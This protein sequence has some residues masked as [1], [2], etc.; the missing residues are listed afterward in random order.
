MSQKIKGLYIGIVG[1]IFL[2]L[3]GWLWNIYFE[4]KQNK[5]NGPAI[6]S[7]IFKEV[8][9]EDAKKAL[10]SGE[11]DMYS[12]FL[13]VADAKELKNNSAIILYPTTSTIIG[14]YVNPY[15]AKNGELNPFSIKEV[16]SAMQ[17][18]VNRQKIVDDVYSGFAQSTLTFPWKGLADYENIKNTVEGLGISYDKEKAISLIKKGMESS[19]A[20]LESGVWMY[21]NKPVIIKI[22]QSSKTLEIANILKSELDEI[23]FTTTSIYTDSND[24]EARNPESYTNAAD[25][26][27]N[28]AISGFT[29][30]GQSKINNTTI[31][32]PY[33]GDGWWEYTNKEIDVLEEKQK[34]FRTEE[35]RLTINNELVK[36][37][38]DDSTCVWLVTLDSVSAA[39]SEVKGLIQDKYIG[40]TNFTNLREAY[41][42]NKEVLIVGLPK[43]YEEK[44]GWNHW[45]IN[46]I[47]MM[48]IVNTVH[49]PA[50]WTE[51]YTLKE[52]G[53]RWFPS[54]SNNGLDAT[55]D[56]PSDS[57][58]WNAKEKKWTGVGKEKKAVTKVTYDLSRYLEANWHNGEKIT[59]ADVVYH[60]ART[61]DVASDEKKQ[62]LE[63]DQYLDVF[64][65]VIGIRI[66]NKM[67]EVYL[68]TWSVDEGELLSIAGIFQKVAP[69]ELS[70][71]TDDLVFNQ[72]LYDYHF[73]DESKNEKLNLSNAIHIAA[74]F[75]TIKGLDFAKI[76]P[77]LTMGDKVYAQKSDLDLR[78]SLLES[79]YA[80]HNHLYVSDG[81]F[82]IDSFDIPNKS[83]KLKAFRDQS[84]P[85]SA[86]HWRN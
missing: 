20:S 21:K 58:V 73:I 41:I 54:I 6:D 53:F 67:L 57:F 9:K 22:S 25:L 24:P 28:I 84:Y 55:I 71:A 10:L 42:P 59:Q 79:W 86:N 23:G 18:L 49:D 14:L 7:I 37:Y 65:P 75:K 68:N 27:W 64:K 31:L 2:I 29:F 74:I 38:L 45:T 66:D 11:I 76:Q 77:M 36:N 62:K 83:I 19:G 80:K 43:F 61:W 34:N 56:I 15:P 72:R 33:V 13:P 51:T 40:I 12:G 8:K 50:V 4:Q 16:R 5:G 39:R 3:I 63:N 44:D 35:E 81:P 85:F 26:K 60:I 1:L 46:D 78:V 32:D 48:Y 52:T 82:Y 47:N 70:A 30:Y 69:W 17:F